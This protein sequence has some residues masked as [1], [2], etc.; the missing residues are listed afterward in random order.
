MSFLTR[1]FSKARLPLLTLLILAGLLIGFGVWA[2]VETRLIANPRRLFATTAPKPVT[3]AAPLITATK[4][5]TLATDVNSNGFVN[6]GD[7]LMYSVVVGNSGTDATGVSFSDTLDANL[8]LVGGSVMASPVAVD[9]SYPCTGNLSISIPAGSGVLANDYL[10]LNPLATITAS[11]T[12]ST[13]GG[14]VAVMSDGSFTYEP[15]AGYTGT[16]TFTYTLM[17]STGSSTGTVSITVSNKVWFINNAAAS[18]TTAAAGCGRF[19]HP[20]SSLS[21]FITANPD[22]SGD[23]IFIYQGSSSY[24]G[25]LTL[26]TNERLIGQGDALDATTLGFTPAANGPTLPS[27]TAKPT[28]TN[29]LT[30]AQG[31]TVLAISMSTGASTGIIGSGGL[32]GLT[33]GDSPTTATNGITVTTTTGTTVSLNNVGGNFTF[34]SLSA[35]GATTG[36]ALTSTPASLNFTVTGDN[37][38]FANGSGGTIQNITGGVLGNAPAYF[39]TAS[40][41]VTLKSMNMAITVNAFSG[42]HVDNNAGGTIT[43]NVTGCTFTGVQAGNSVQNKALLQFE[44][45]NTGGGAANI[46]ANVQ[47]SFFFDNRT[48]GV[49][50]IAAGDSMMNVTLNQS[51]FGTEV[52]TGAPVNQPGTTITN[53]PPFSALISNSSN[54]K[55]DYSITNNTFWGADGLKGALYA[56]TISGATNVASSRLNGT[57]SGNK[58][59]KT[60]VVGSGCSSNC[61]GIGLL[62]GTGGTFNATVTNND[63]RQV[64]AFGINFVN[65]VT[66]ANGT[67]IGRITNNTIAEPDITLMP[68]FIRGIVVADGNSGGSTANWCAE[69]TGNNISGSWQAGFFIRI[70]SN[71]TTGILTIPGL[72]PTTGATAAQVNSYIQGLNTLPANSVGTTVGTGPINGG[73]PCPLLLADGGIWATADIFSWL[74]SPVA[75]LYSTGSAPALAVNVA[76]A[77]SHSS[78]NQPVVTPAANTITS[79]SQQQL[80]SIVAAVIARWS[81][82]GLTREQLAFLRGLKFQIIDLPGAYLSE[83]D[84]DRIL[85]DRDAGGNGWFIGANALDEADFAHAASATR[86]YT[87]PSG[88]PAGRID[89]LTAILHETGHCLGLDD[90][91]A[92]SD[93]DNLMY[94]YLTMGERRLPLKDQARYAQP[95]HHHGTHFLSLP[96]VAAP[97]P[98]A[99]SLSVGTLPAG[100]SVT[101]KFNATISSSFTGNAITNQ[102]NVTAAGGVN[103]NSNNLA[104]PVIQAPGIVKSFAPAN[105]AL[106]N[107]NQTISTLTL[108]LTNLNTSQQLTNV[109]FSD[110]LPSGLVVDTTPTPTTTGCGA[111]TFAPAAN[112]TL[113]NFGSGTINVGTPCVVTV[114]VKGTSVGAK[115]NTANGATSTQANIGAASNTA[116]LNVLTAPSF[117]KSFG[118]STV[119]AGGTT[120]LTFNIT[121]NDTA[122]GLTGVNFSDPLPTGLTVASTPNIV[123]GCGGGT[124]MAAANSGTISLSGASLAA[125]GN[126]SFSVDV[127][128]TTAGAKGNSVSLIT[129][130]TGTNNTPAT[131]TLNVFGPPT[132]SKVFATNPIVVGQTSVLNITI[133]NPASNPGSLT[134][135]SFTDT[136]P[137]GISAPNSSTASCGG[138]TLAVSGNVITLTN[139]SLA[140][141]ANCVNSVTVTGIAASGSAYTNTISSVSSTNGGTNSTP[142]TANITVNKASTTASITADTPD[143]SV[144]GQPYAVT[145]GVAVTA[146]GSATPT[147]P[148]GTITVSDGSQS[149][150][151]NMPGTSCNLTSTT[152]GAKTLTATYN[153]DSNFNASAVSS[154]VAHTVN[155]AN[156]TTA[157]T[158]DTPDPSNPGQAV[159]VNFTVTP[160]SP[161]TGTLTGN[162]TISDSASAAT[163]TASVAAGTC[164]I[165]LTTPGSR[166]LTATYAGDANFNTS[167]SAG[168]PHQV[169]TPPTIAKSFTSAQIKVGETS[170]MSF[171]IANPNAALSLSN[172]SFSDTF[173]A[174]IEV[175]SPVVTTN[176]CGGSFSPALAGGA[177]NFSYSGGSLAGGASPCT[178]SVQVKATS[179][180]L[181]NNTTGTI[182]ATE[183]GTGA[184]S[185]TATLTVVGAPTLAKSFSPA[186]ILFGQTSSLGFTIT[187]SNTT[188]ALNGINFTDTLPAGMTVATSGPTATCGGMLSTTAPNVISFTGGMLA[189]GNP[190]PTTCSFNVTVTPTQPGMLNN[191]SGVISATESGPGATSNTATLTVSKSNTTTL[192]SSNVNPSVFGQSVTFT[193]TVAAVPPGSGIP[194]GSV[195][196]LIDGN[197]QSPVALVAG[198]ATLT[199]STLTVATHPVVANYAGDT[200]F[201]SSGSATLNQV[202]NKASTTLSNLSD[203]PDPSVT[204]ESY[205]AGFTLN[206]TAPGGGTPTGTVTVADGTGGTCTATLPA[207]SC[208]ISSTSIG[209]KTLTFTY[210]GDANFNGS[211]NTTGH[212]VNKADTTTTITAV[213]PDPSVFGGNVTVNYSVVATAPGGGT[214]TGNVVVTVSGG[215]ETCTGTV[216]AGSCTLALTTPG[217]RTLTATYVGDA[218]YN[219]SSDTEAHTV[220]KAD[221]TTTIVSDNPDSSAVGQN[222]T[223]LYT[224]VASAPGT[225]TPSGNVTVSDGVNSCTG[226][227]AAGSC[228]LALT[229]PGDRTLTATYASDTNFNGSSDTE[230]HTVVAPPTMSK[231]FSPSNVSVGQTSTLTFT[232]TNPAAN[233]VALTGVGFTDSFPNTP[234]LVVAAPLTVTNTCG[235]TVQNS[236]GGV[237]IAGDTGIKLAGGTVGTNAP[238]TCTISVNVTPQA[239]GPFNNV[240]GAVSSTNGGTGNTASATLLTNEP[241]TLTTSNIART[242]GVGSSNS[243]IGLAAD[244]EDAANTLQIQVSKDGV[245]FGNSATLN[246]V[247]VTLSDLNGSATGMNPDAAG[248]VF[249]DAVAA[250]GATNATFSL[251]VTDSGGQTSTKTFTVNLTSQPT[252]IISINDVTLNEGN[253]GTT[254]FTFTVGLN[255]ANLCQTITVNY[256]TANGTATTADSDYTATSGMLSFAPGET[257]KSLTVLVNSDLNIE[258]NETFFLNLTTPVNATIADNQGLGTITN[259]DFPPFTSSLTDPFVCNGI[260]SSILV[261]AQL[262]NPNN[263]P[264]AGT[265]NVTLP[266]SLTLVPGTCMSSI[267]AC[268]PTPPTQVAWSGNIPAGQTV[269]FTYQA[270]IADGTPDGTIITINSSGSVNG[271]GATTSASGTVSCPGLTQ[272]PEDVKT[273]D[274]KA[275]SLVVFPYYISKSGSGSDTKLHLSNTGE[276][277]AFV[278]LFFI[279]GATCNQADYSVCLTPNASLTFLA[280]EMDPDTTGW[281]IALVVDAQGNPIQNNGLIGNAFVND[282]NYVGNY[283][284]ES[285]WAYSNN[286]ATI[287]GDKATLRF[288]GTAYDAMPNQF[289]V[290]IQS[291]RDVVGQKIVTVGMSGDITR[292]TLT[293][294]AQLGIGVAYN[295]N[296]KP[297]GSFSGFL[298]GICQATGTI[299]GISPRVPFTIAGIIPSGQVG[300]IKLNIGGGV[301]LLLTPQSSKKW[302]GIRGL[303][304][305]GMTFTTIT[306]PVLPPKC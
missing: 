169:A 262:T 244:K 225:G 296:E 164:N 29:T 184:T 297:F 34:R 237:L 219:G 17:N 100:K 122:F 248:K 290:E 220:N 95:G 195:V 1:R 196:F 204:G 49:A 280:S 126:C 281:L 19:S 6:P 33:V 271:I 141:G 199:T 101:I 8:T 188:V 163:C 209:A 176:T 116:T 223:V 80:D 221:T 121:N 71:N 238:R 106:A 270:Q 18:C 175:D 75:N 179:A 30:L 295:G 256:A 112:A 201:N 25:A 86:R 149:C 207:T 160:N 159:A 266:A 249:A 250:C 186:S 198:Q 162:V 46:T 194:T 42:M 239:Q 213:N 202:V 154:G 145:A 102:A 26:K 157:I 168:E 206:V 127:T 90:S 2:A 55:V 232:I 89:L 43:V 5:A 76:S 56:V 252:P 41:V 53:P 54:A 74:T 84:G 114:K 173:P 66:G 231:I 83:A 265:F 99:V 183:T 286:L 255:V 93:R 28:L 166:T 208:S 177:T 235:G 259:D 276:V 58:I 192:L 117:T 257:S 62:P 267:G 118:A 72:T 133:T 272:A 304:K 143:P 109:A 21:S 279:D 113:L 138:G 273:S 142:A 283:G 200:N 45:G 278:H 136:L 52:N 14:T 146:P 298:N 167:A 63:I 50:A 203:T 197:P 299:T 251:R 60:G 306:I 144:V 161:G 111:P 27:A 182:S 104:T 10:G 105:I 258:P 171:S 107:T 292:N 178:I 103:I 31:V 227:V 150:T 44:G 40:G 214:P 180:G 229:T 12:T 181:K 22:A 137:A 32:T 64:S 268:T 301:G 165:T 47:N 11:A 82:A 254:A 185:N 61:A 68:L 277:S 37:S 147:A 189:A 130:E 97:P 120:A 287:N 228:I 234:N 282:G 294:A 261:T 151:I 263:T 38:G 230:S 212:Q 226:T 69:V 85:V 274:Q 174:G 217:N 59:G 193:A 23:R 153:G 9:D 284:A 241:P 289:A 243:Q 73:S 129:T 65:S 24:S 96:S 67:S 110:S 87:D 132:I 94:G 79:L 4:T 51:G 246:G 3:V 70:T 125:S 48:Y 155:K 158:A 216:G 170:V 78:V 305:T 242:E 108:T 190:N 39:L 285:F 211:S 156:T 124:I 236:G 135:L 131:A 264:Q 187:N 36:L 288:N 115:A 275:G 302:S 215:A 224:V 98:S 240:S 210:S 88:A 57:I 152:A 13:N 253:A 123:G 205:T 20:Y 191:T 291:P 247:T 128:G 148:T 16:D 35:N 303:H 92:Q 218:N 81:A 15:T 245:T 222:V 300:T 260:G 119:T 269:T 172:I 77:A 139:G 7:T 233:T 140:S 293:G 91:Y 134:G